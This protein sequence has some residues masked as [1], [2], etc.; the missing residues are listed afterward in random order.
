[1]YSLGVSFYK[2]DYEYIDYTQDQLGGSISLGRQFYRHINASVGV[3]YVDNDSSY[4][5]S[6]IYDPD[7]YNAYYDQYKKASVFTSVSFDNTDDFYTPREGWKAALSLEYSSLDGDDYNA[8]LYPEGY[9]DIFKVS[10]KVG[11]YYGLEDWIDYDMIIRLKGRFTSITSVDG[12]YI[13]IAERLFLGGIGSVRG[14]D[15]YSISPTILRNGYDY[16]IGG[17]DRASG[18]IEA[19][20]PLSEAAKMRLAFFY[21][22]GWITSDTVP[23]AEYG[24]VDF[25]NI[26]RSSTGVVLEWQSGFGPIN[27]V[28]AWPIDDEDYDQTSVFEFSMGT[29]F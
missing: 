18:S 27:L 28:F 26:T 11:Y 19:S 13:P 17:T 7:V 5:D 16:R 22:Y 23:T 6:Y 15:P 4:N 12:D 29:K 8:T 20:I 25:G 24:D 21:D 9:A 1:M 2:R 14:Y 3:G 10:G